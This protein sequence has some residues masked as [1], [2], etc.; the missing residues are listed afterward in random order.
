[1]PIEDDD[2]MRDAIECRPE[3]AGLAS[4]DSASQEENR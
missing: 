1:M 4:H 2:W 3:A